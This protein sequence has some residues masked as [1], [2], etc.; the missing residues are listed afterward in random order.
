[1]KYLI[2]K[3]WFDSMENHNTHGY[4]VLGYLDSESEAKTFCSTGRMFTKKDN[5][6]FFNGDLPEY[7]YKKLNN[8]N[9]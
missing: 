8:L 2:E 4:E 1:M 5:W 9:E 6:S 3:L 7:R